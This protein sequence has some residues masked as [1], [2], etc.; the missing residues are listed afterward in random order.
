MA[1]HNTQCPHCFTTYVISDD[2]LRVSEGMVR[3]GT[4]RERFQARIIKKNTETPYFDPREA[5][6][7]PLTEKLDRQSQAASNAD[8]ESELQKFSFADP[9]TESEKS[10]SLSDATVSD[11]VNSEMS[12]DID[13]DA[14]VTPLDAK[15]LSAAKMLANIRA[16][17]ALFEQR[18]RTEK[19]AAENAT[20]ENTI[21]EKATTKNTTKNTTTEDATTEDGPRE[22]ATDAVNPKTGQHGLALALSERG[23][24]ETKRRSKTTKK[25]SPTEVETGNK[26]SLIDQVGSLVD[27]KRVNSKPAKA[28][29]DGIARKKGVKNSAVTVD[30][31]FQ[32]D[33]KPKV[34]S[35]AWLLVPPLL[36]IIAA[37]AIT[38]TYQLWMKQ[39][40]VLKNHSFVQKKL[41]EL[42]VP[43]TKKLAEYEVF[44]P[45]RRNLS[46]LELASAHTDAHPT[47]SSTTL[48][49]ISIINHAQIEQPL[50]WIEVAL[51]NADGHLVSRRKLSP[52]DY[53]YQNATN[54]SIGARELKKVTI[55]LLS[56]PKQATGYEVK[57]LSK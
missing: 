38:L 49:K 46:K 27:N 48:L 11:N 15:Q 45:V 8:T 35:Y 56:F 53:V 2:Q 22:V 7:E 26:E 20:S 31:P 55:E 57:M 3:C 21:S 1:L 6:I 24:V 54:T 19:A 51:T 32:L 33:R 42:S 52:N 36:M 9:H 17:Q 25:P 47:R 5:F 40:L 18:R 16:K 14:P 34:R 12:L 37:L 30:S 43:L 23:N 50:P 28:L 39:I 13:H 29:A 41:A 10:I 44:L 4:C